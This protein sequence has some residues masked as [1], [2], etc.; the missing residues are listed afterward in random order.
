MDPNTLEAIRQGAILYII[1]ACSI[2]IHEWAHALTAHKL[3]DR[4][5]QS[6]GRVT[7]NPLAHMELIGTVI[8]PAVSIFLPILMNG[9][10]GFFIFGWGRPVNTSPAK[11][12]TGIR[13][14]LIVR[15]AG[16][17][18]NLLGALVIATTGGLISHIR[19]DLSTLCQLAIYINIVLF[20]FNIIP[21]P[22][23]DGSRFLKH[24][25]NMSDHA[26][27]K[28]SNY[29]FII[30]IAAMNIPIFRTIF[31]GFVHT[32]VEAMNYVMVW[33]FKIL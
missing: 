23:L 12:A 9:D 5:P 15:A 8:F 11:S 19:L 24:A 13:N 31:G 29:G 2:V 6:E 17:I 27:A 18:V 26:Y 7:L 21:I 25:I 14:E 33:S 4:L 10:L 22:P 3:G 32:L 20:S 30:L 16:P 1:L 28:L